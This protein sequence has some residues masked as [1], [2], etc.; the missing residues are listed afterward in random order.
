MKINEKINL[1]LR[2]QICHMQE[3][4]S[5]CPLDSWDDDKPLCNVNTLIEEATK[6]LMED[7][8][9]AEARARTEDVVADI[10]IDIG[11]PANGQGYPML[12]EAVM[13]LINDPE[14]INQVTQKLYSHVAEKCSTNWRAA[15]R[16]MRH[17]I[18]RAM[19]RCNPDT[20]FQYFG[21][22]IHP[23]KGGPS[24][25]EFLARIA[26]IARRKTR[27]ADHE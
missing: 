18:E 23:G 8:D 27:R 17:C 9:P 13:Y 10:L 7:E 15:E 26:D 3:D 16:N 1:L 14:S 24:L 11:V 20:I 2:M 4:C 6:A 22:S 21:N 12:V 5:R 25:S 19:E